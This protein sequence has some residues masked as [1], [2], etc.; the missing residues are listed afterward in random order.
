MA[1]EHQLPSEG[2]ASSSPALLVASSSAA[3]NAREQ[4]DTAMD[5]AVMESPAQDLVPSERISI[6]EEAPRPVSSSNVNGDAAVQVEH[7]NAV[8]MDG[9]VV[10]AVES[11]DAATD[12]AAADAS[13]SVDADVEVSDAVK[14]SESS[15]S[16][17]VSSD[18]EPA[19][20]RSRKSVRFP[21]E[22][23]MSMARC[24]REDE[25]SL[26][27]NEK[28]LEAQLAKE[29]WVLRTGGDLEAAC[30]SQQ[31]VA[32]SFSLDAETLS[33][34][35]SVLVHNTAFEK[36]V[37]V[38]YTCNFWLTEEETLCA[39]ETA[40]NP[41]IDRF[42]FSLDLSKSFSDGAF[43]VCAIRYECAGVESWDNNYGNNYVAQFSYEKQYQALQEACNQT[44]STTDALGVH[45]F[46]PVRDRLNFWDQMT[47]ADREQK[48]M[49]AT[50]PSDP[51]NASLWMQPAGA[52]A[53]GRELFPP[54]KETPKPAANNWFAR[55]ALFSP[56]QTPSPV[57]Q[58]QQQQQTVSVTSAVSGAGIMPFGTGFAAAAA[59][60]NSS[61]NTS[62]TAASSSSNTTSAAATA[63]H[64]GLRLETTHLNDVSSAAP[65]PTPTTASSTGL[66]VAPVAR[67]APS[68]FPSPPPSPSKLAV[69][70]SFYAPKQAQSK[71]SPRLSSLSASSSAS[72]SSS[73]FSESS[74]LGSRSASQYSYDGFNSGGGSD[75]GSSG[76]G[77]VETY[78]YVGGSF[79]SHDR[80]DQLGGDA[81]AQYSPYAPYSPYSQASPGGTR[82][83][84]SRFWDSP[85]YSYSSTTAQSTTS[86]NRP[87]YYSSQFEDS[88]SY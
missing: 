42:S 36:E 15:E 86:P 40:V 70:S 87:S 81:Y 55:T 45:H 14:A 33:L 4:H 54:A 16:I 7:S 34:R 21:E 53:A 8:D 2:L 71:E 60:G 52:R 85:G 74:S 5:D 41:S 17:A 30:V 61:S 72:P 47:Y 12:D 76:I 3:S 39:Y 38:R 51:L 18:A 24:F 62:N 56:V 28:Y 57:P 27:V 67:K 48:E 9:P 29:N 58:Q 10:D 13:A 80:L 84:E 11:G 43:F 69:I 35:G 6:E 25:P 88:Y 20:G 19:S 59:L 49:S 32:E 78:G 31:V 73:A 77:G 83:S 46:A 63:E 37:S 66:L 68:G 1:S 26:L 79:G 22:H 50:S 23:E 64:V 44:V 65:T 75:Y 82:A